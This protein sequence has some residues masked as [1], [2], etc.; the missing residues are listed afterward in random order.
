M[1]FVTIRQVIAC[2]E[3]KISRG[4]EEF[5]L[6]LGCSDV[7]RRNEYCNNVIHYK[8]SNLCAVGAAA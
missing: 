1:S 7:G 3:A 2:R 6:N 4:G 5:A 8:E